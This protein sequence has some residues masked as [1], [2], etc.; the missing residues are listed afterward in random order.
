MQHTG[1]SVL[2]SQLDDPEVPPAVI[3]TLLT[4]DD[5]AEGKHGGPSC[6]GLVSAQQAV[7]C[8]RASLHLQLIWFRALPASVELPGVPAVI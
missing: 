7:A 8:R 2:P 1:P 3:E 4:A 5:S 6:K